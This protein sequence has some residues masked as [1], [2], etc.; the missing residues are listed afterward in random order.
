M[1]VMNVRL[2]LGLYLVASLSLQAQPIQTARQVK[3][4]SDLN[5]GDWFSL[6]YIKYYPSLEGNHS[7]R[8]A[9]IF[10]YQIMVSDRSNSDLQ[11]AIRPTRVCYHESISLGNLKLP[12]SQ[13]ATLNKYSLYSNLN[14]PPATGIAS[15]LM[16]ETKGDTTRTITRGG[17]YRTGSFNYFDSNYWGDFVLENPFY[18]G[19]RDVVSFKLNLQNGLL[20]DTSY[21]LEKRDWQYPLE[22]ISDGIMKKGAPMSFAHAHQ[23]KDAKSFFEEIICN[24]FTHVNPLAELPWLLDGE[25]EDDVTY[26]IQI[27]GAPFQLTPNVKLSYYSPKRLNS[28]D[29]ILEIN[30]RTYDLQQDDN[31]FVRFDFFLS[32]PAMGMMI[33]T[34]VSITPGD[35]IVMETDR[36]GNVT[37]SGQGAENC[38]YWYEFNKHRAFWDS[39]PKDKENYLGN[40]PL[41]TVPKNS[42]SDLEQHLSIGDSIFQVLQKQYASQMSPYWLESAQLSFKYWSMYKILQSHL[43]HSTKIEWEKD[44][45]QSVTPLMDYMLRPYYYLRY[46][47]SVSPI[48]S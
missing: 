38:H 46:S 32:H 35:S 6:E 30:H 37:F 33:N 9:D 47:V 39:S 29:L 26:R 31:G 41:S 24:Y 36:N 23:Q 10:E 20:S 11:L 7:L 3:T 16:L 25:M 17:I 2:L 28:K 4:F 44:P 12:K 19:T 5:K 34:D 15:N 22:N 8:N 43:L 21:Y 13:S 27:I 14:D 45:F 1:Y 18:Y 42:L 40:Y 48:P